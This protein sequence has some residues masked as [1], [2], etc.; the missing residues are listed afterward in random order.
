MVIATSGT[1][2]LGR[3]S[4]LADT[5]GVAGGGVY[6]LDEETGEVLWSQDKKSEFGSYPITL[7]GQV[8]TMS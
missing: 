4:K 2:A 6:G 1:D 8:G 3:A 5:V 7:C